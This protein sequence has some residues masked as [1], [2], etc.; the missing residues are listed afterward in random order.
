MLFLKSTKHG[1]ATKLFIL[2]NECS[3]DLKLAILNTNSTFELESPHQHRR[4]VA[5]RAIRTAKT[6]LLA[7]I[8]TC[9]PDFP[10]TEW[11]RLLRQSKLTLNLLRPSRINTNLSA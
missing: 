9:D 3:N 11:D 8:A 10:I 7:G 4:N 6:H 1:H 2:D 5:Q